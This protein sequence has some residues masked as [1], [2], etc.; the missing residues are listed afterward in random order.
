MLIVI[1]V[2]VL[3]AI[4]LG[5][6]GWL[7]ASGESGLRGEPPAQPDLG[8]EHRPLTADDVP[9]LR[10]RLAFRGYRM[11]DVDAALDRLTESLRDAE[12]RAGEPAEDGDVDRA[13]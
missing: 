7:F 10:F 13:E 6:V 5:A 3:G 9:A 8:P 1:V 4:I 2:A 11:S 12:N